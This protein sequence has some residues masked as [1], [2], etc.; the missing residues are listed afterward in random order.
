SVPVMAPASPARRSD[1]A[2]PLSTVSVT[3]GAASY[4][5]YVVPGGS[6]AA[7]RRPPGTRNDRPP[8]GGD[9]PFVGGRCRIRTCV[10]IRRRIYSPL[11][12]AARTTC[13]A[14]GTRPCADERITAETC[15]TEPE[16]Q[17]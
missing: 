3:T 15:R 14:R 6:V 12:L 17:E 2:P 5:H 13:R 1:I 4:Q 8:R 10:G 7:P 9:R 16:Q 11:P